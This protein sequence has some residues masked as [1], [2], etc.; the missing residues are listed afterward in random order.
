[1]HKTLKR[2]HLSPSWKTWHEYVTKKYNPYLK[3]GIFWKGQGYFWYSRQLWHQNSLLYTF[4]YN[5]IQLKLFFFTKDTT[6]LA[7]IWVSVS[8]LLCYMYLSPTL[9]KSLSINIKQNMLQ[10]SVT[11]FQITLHS[12]CFSY[13]LPKCAR[14]ILYHPCGKYHLMSRPWV[15]SLPNYINSD[16]KYKFQLARQ[17]FTH[18]M[19]DS[20]RSMSSLFSS[21]IK[22]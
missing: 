18:P 12:G 4:I 8:H 2:I 13:C 16:L 9:P 7:D 1:M 19:F 10:K 11:P 22:C 3:Q 14:W 17:A 21:T 20:F 5:I 6:G 15:F